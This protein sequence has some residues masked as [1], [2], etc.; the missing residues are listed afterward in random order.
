MRRLKIKLSAES[1]KI[2]RDNPAYTRGTEAWEKAVKEIGTKSCESIFLLMT[3]TEAEVENLH[4]VE[5]RLSSND[6]FRYFHFT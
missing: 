4:H 2:I 3:L 5:K 1:K 6:Y